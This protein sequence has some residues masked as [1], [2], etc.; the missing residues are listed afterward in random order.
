MF[1]G[2]E[3]SCSDECPESQ[4]ERVLFG[5]QMSREAPGEL[6]GIPSD[7]LGLLEDPTKSVERTSN[8]SPIP[9]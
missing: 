8:L 9:D 1:S 7:Q 5:L 6:L 3:Y 2:V 4:P